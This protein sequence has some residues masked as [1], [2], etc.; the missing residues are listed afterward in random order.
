M[1][2]YEELIRAAQGCHQKCQIY[3]STNITFNI[4]SMK[5]YVDDKVSLPTLAATGAQ[6]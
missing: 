4:I 3:F 5:G 2:T 6:G 1:E